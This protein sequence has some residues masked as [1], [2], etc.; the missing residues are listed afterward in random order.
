MKILRTVLISL[1][2]V[3]TATYAMDNQN[4]NKKIINDPIVKE[5]VKK[6]AIILHKMAVY[7]VPP[8]TLQHYLKGIGYVHE[9]NNIKALQI[10]FTNNV[11]KTVLANQIPDNLKDEFKQAHEELSNHIPQE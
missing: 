10:V 4:T 8:P 3:C 11:S 2:I 5:D 9:H 7:F 6:I 1:L